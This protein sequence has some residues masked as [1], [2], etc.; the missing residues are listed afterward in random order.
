MYN[1]RVM[2]RRHFLSTVAA[3]PAALA[4]SGQP[5]LLGGPTFLKSSDPRELARESRRLG[6][7]AAYCP[8]AT[9]KDAALLKAIEDGFAA[10]K[11]T[12]AEMGV[13][14]NLMDADA[15]K[16][17]ENL[18]KV[19]EGL[20]VADAVG[21]RC[22]VD[23]AGS[24]HEKVWY[25]PDPKNFSKAFFDAAVE[26]ARKII[27]AVKPKRAKFAYEM[28]GWSVPDSPDSYLRL[29]KAIDRAGFGVHIDICNG[30][31]TPERFYNNAAF[32][33]ECF[34]KLGR[35]IVSCHA[36]DLDWIPE[37]NVHFVEVIPGRGKID[38]RPYLRGVASLPAPAPLMLEHL[39][40][41]EEYAEGAS[42]IRKVA[43]E[44]GV[45]LA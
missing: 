30:I 37:M 15:A 25:G 1:Q 3:A 7:S 8:R 43:A 35:W 42:Y 28:M 33:E 44:S 31:S 20:A 18:E 6:Y 12:L 32:T 36:K 16:R 11:V 13:W 9:M 2:I 34:R 19:T 26:N 38:Y 5:V 21:A 40:T 17:K 29:L 14:V 22:C 24:F 41:A 23:I 39:K 27:D 4:A 10:E 45:K